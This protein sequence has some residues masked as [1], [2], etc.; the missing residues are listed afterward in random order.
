MGET[1][2]GETQQVNF[3]YHIPLV[4][5]VNIILQTAQIRALRGLDRL[6]D[7]GF[8]EEEIAGIRRQF[9]SRESYQQTADPDMSIE[10]RPSYSF[11]K[12]FFTVLIK[13]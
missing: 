5:L 6:Q 10:E 11:L 2:D 13:Q 12:I 8:T 7:A 9:H 1:D 4:C 3:V